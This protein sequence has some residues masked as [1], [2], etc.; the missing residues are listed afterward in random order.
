[1]K[2]YS[3][4]A[5]KNK[6]DN[7]D[8]QL[9]QV[10][11]PVA[12]PYEFFTDISFIPVFNQKMLGACVGH[13]H[14][15][16]HI[17][18]DL[19]E[20]NKVPKLSPRYIYAL[21]K[22]IDGLAQEGTY[23]RISAKIEVDKGCA[24][25]NIVPNNTD[26]SHSEYIKIVETPEINTD[27]KPFKLKGY[28]NVI[29]DKNL[30]KQAII[31]NGLVAITIS[32]G[33]FDNPIKKG[34]YGLHRV[35]CYGFSGDK[36]Y[37]RN[38]WGENWGDKGNGYFE[39]T[40]QELSDMLVF[41]DLPNEILL[42]AKKKY[43]YFT[44]NEVKGL[45]E[46]FVRKL[47]IMREQCGFPFKIESGF[48]TQAQND[49]LADSVSDSAHL[50]GLAVDIRIVDSSKRF[51]LL[52]VAFNNGIRRIGIGRNFIHLDADNSKPQDVAWD[53]YK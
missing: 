17:Y 28:A 37:F 51:K 24:T 12:V 38:S 10:Q 3:L 27:A 7:R 47:D 2:Q 5:I 53:Y 11:S 50:S 46:E 30:L 26:L 29:N 25:E 45:K 43:K 40:D 52:Q 31:S 6:K 15:V 35:V 13:A 44:E 32:V 42:E 34:N 9:A 21:S 22:Q 33:N 14:A 18:N 16:I 49:A 4:G 48:R 19:K 39:W 1:M 20:N 36:F 41:L 8:I 23:P